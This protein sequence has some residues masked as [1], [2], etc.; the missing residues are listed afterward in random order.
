MTNPK[1]V[2]K[3]WASESEWQSFSIQG[4]EIGV[5]SVD[6]GKRDNC[7]KDGS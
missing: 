3:A 5:V 1:A 6:F 2:E 7:A 4:V